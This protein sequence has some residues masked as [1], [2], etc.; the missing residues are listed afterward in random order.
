VQ[1]LDIL[2]DLAIVN[3][4]IFQIVQV[5]H[6]VSPGNSTHVPY[7]SILSIFYRSDDLPTLVM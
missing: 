3:G 5:L 2:E 6:T 4:K 1:N 7:L